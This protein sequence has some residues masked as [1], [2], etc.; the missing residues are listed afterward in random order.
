MNMVINYSAFVILAILWL[1]FA[2]A[3]IFN[4]TLLDNT[5]QFFRGMPVVI[6]LVVGFLVLPVV[7]GLWI[8]ESSW[9]LWFRLI[10]VL[11][12][13]VATIYTFFPK[14]T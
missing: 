11:G 3:L 9:P 5:W 4:P 12:L 7:L 2:A 6:Q 1:G 14:Q 13:G 8:W 10:F